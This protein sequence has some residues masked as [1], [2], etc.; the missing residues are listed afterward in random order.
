MRLHFERQ[1]AQKDA[2]NRI[3]DELRQGRRENVMKLGHSVK[4]LSTK[5]ADVDDK[6][7]YDA[8]VEDEKDQ[9]G[10]LVRHLTEKQRKLMTINKLRDAV[11]ERRQIKESQ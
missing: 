2:E 10:K 6:Y 9:L 1:Q 3:R 5:A 11:L 8:E 7:R 4:M